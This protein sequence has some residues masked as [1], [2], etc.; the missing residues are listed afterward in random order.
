MRRAA[1]E[2]NLAWRRATPIEKGAFLQAMTGRNYGWDET[3]D[4]WHWFH[5]GYE[6]GHSHGY[7]E[8]ECNG[9]D[10]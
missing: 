8:G 10:V 6:I 4:A 7:E 9:S 1:L 2:A 5:T 3:L